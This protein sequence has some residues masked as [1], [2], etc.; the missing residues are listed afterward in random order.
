M[1]TLY[2][3]IVDTNLYSGNFEREMCAYIT[4]QIGECGVGRG[5][6][7]EAEDELNEN[8]RAWF[9]ENIELRGEEGEKD[10]CMRPCAIVPTPGRI[11]N[12]TGGH[13]N[14]EGYTGQHCYPAY[15]SVAIFVSA[16][17][18]AAI[19]RVAKERAEKFAKNYRDTMRKGVSPMTILNVRLT[20]GIK[21]VQALDIE[22]L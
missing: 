8:V 20:K 15:E 2:T 11:N 13:F 4:G 10:S 21:K 7:S 22:A 12:G 9:E 3:F 1:P 16:K 17:P 18:T 19:F 14:T 5:D 6:A